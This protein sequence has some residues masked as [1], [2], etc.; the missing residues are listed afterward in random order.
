MSDQRATP[1]EAADY[2]IGDLKGGSAEQIDLS[3]YAGN[4]PVRRGLRLSGSSYTVV[5]VSSGGVDFTAHEEV[6]FEEIWG[7]EQPAETVQRLLQPALE[8]G[9]PAEHPAVQTLMEQAG[10]GADAD[11]DAL[12]G[13]LQTLLAEYPE[14]ARGVVQALRQAAG[15]PEAFAQAADGLA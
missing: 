5:N 1:P 13:A 2:H 15:L 7:S 10:R 12:R 6:T 3:H 14:P 8:A 11:A 4:P 9:A